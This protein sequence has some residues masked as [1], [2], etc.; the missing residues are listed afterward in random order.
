MKPQFHFD[1]AT[2][3]YTL[4]GV[5]VPSVTQIIQSLLPL[6]PIDPWYLERGRATHLACEL[7]DRGT[8][9][10]SSVDSEIEPRVRA[11]EKFRQDWPAEILAN[12]L[13]LASEK[14]QFA[15][16]LDRMLIS[17]RVAPTLIDLKNSFSPQYYLQLA[18]YSI[19][20]RENRPV[21]PYNAGAV[22][23]RDDGTYRCH[24]MTRYELQTAEQQFLALLTVYGFAT[25]HNLLKGKS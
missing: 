4:D 23:L 21:K 6:P 11:W 8:L 9:D 1:A 2:H 17:D 15:G 19:L 24:W 7:L 18:G 22:E 16:T 3:T 14:Y 5:R 10:W 20:W 12:E 25:K 13:P